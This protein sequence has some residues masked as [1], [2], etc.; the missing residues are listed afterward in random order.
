[1]ILSNIDLNLLLVLDTVL[2][3]RSVVRAAQRLH[4][5][6]PA[7]SNALARLRILLGDQLVI[8]SGRGIVPTPHAT[9]LAPSLRRALTELESLVQTD[10]FDPLT[11]TRQFTLAIADA[12]QISNVPQLVKLI[13]K[14]LPHSRLRIV[15]I[16]TY[17][18][19]G[20]LSGTEIDAALVTPVDTTPGVHSMP[21]YKEKSVLTARKGNKGIGAKITRSQLAALKHVEIQV[22]PGRGHQELAEA[23]ARLG[24]ERNIGAIVPNFIAAAAIIAETDLV[25]TLP[26]SLVDLMGERLGLRKIV[27]PA[28]RFMTQIRLVWHER[29]NTDPAMRAFR[30]VV[31]KAVS[32]THR[33]SAR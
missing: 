4:V 28:P 17:I 22:A 25:A 16:D 18:S 14:E 29:T 6:P 15:G 8:R 20:R 19:S 12:G 1:V 24:I 26:A 11:T 31:I 23:Y 33:K 9:N 30:E 5:T 7:V 2:A 32:K 21:V 10:A 27:G 13:G 3:E